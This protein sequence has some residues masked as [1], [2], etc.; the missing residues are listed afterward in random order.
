MSNLQ[1]RKTTLVNGRYY[2][3]FN[4]AQEMQSWEPDYILQWGNW[5]TEFSGTGWYRADGKI[6]ED[7][8]LEE[9]EWP[10]NW[11]FS[12]IKSDPIEDDHEFETGV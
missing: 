11:K 6:E 12:R 1:H 4:T 7:Y 5:K 10:V 2:A 3:F 8:T 9:W